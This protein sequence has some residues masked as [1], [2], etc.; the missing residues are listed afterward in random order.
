MLGKFNYT[1]M[2]LAHQSPY[3]HGR[4]DMEPKDLNELRNDLLA[5]RALASE[6]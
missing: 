3:H 4:L 1:I 6:M 5:K 2:R